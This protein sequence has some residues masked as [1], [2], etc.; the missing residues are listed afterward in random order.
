MMSLN[1]LVRTEKKEANFL[2]FVDI[3]MTFEVIFMQGCTPD[4]FSIAGY[5]Y[6]WS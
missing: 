6:S 5:V 1:V 3:C 2:L 4:G